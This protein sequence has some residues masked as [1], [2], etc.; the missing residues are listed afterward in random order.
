MNVAAKPEPGMETNGELKPVAIAFASIVLPAAGRAEEQEAAL[1]L[2]A[3]A[4]ERLARL[5]EADDAAHL[6]L[7]LR[8]AA[9][10]REPH[11]PLGVAGLEAAHLRQVHHQ[12]QAEQDDE[13]EDQEDRQH[14]HER[15]DLNQ[16]RPVPG[17]RKR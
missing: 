6:L 1:A 7:R 14:H 8:L 13:V 17:G 5:P 16:D 10:V 12:E 3:G 9:H 2:A 4:L 15:E 11:A